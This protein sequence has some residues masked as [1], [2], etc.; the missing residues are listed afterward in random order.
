MAI[1]SK[2]NQPSFP[3]IQL[4]SMQLTLCS[5]YAV[6]FVAALKEL[7]RSVYARRWSTMRRGWM[8]KVKVVKRLDEELNVF[9]EYRH[10]G[11]CFDRP[12]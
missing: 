1:G 5:L 7:E 8:L 9:G 4:E 10:W 3:L 2:D 11:I 12:G 6:A